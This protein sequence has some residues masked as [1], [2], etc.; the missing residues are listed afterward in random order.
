MISIKSS[1]ELELMRRSGKLTASCME[2]LISHVKPGVSTAQLDIIAEQ[3]IVSKGAWPSFKNYRGFPASVCTSVNEE[4]VHGIPSKDKILKDGDILSLD[5]GALLDGYHS[6]MARTVGVGDISGEAKRLISATRDCFYAGMNEAKEGRRLN[7]ISKAVE[8]CAS[9]NGYSV[10]R[11]LVGHGIGRKLHEAPDVPNY[12]F[13]GA[14]PRLRRGMVLCIE[15][16]VNMGGEDVYW[17]ADGWLVI[18][19]DNSL[20]AHYENTVAV[21]ENGPEILTVPG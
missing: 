16:M 4:V 10:V 11:A 12:A 13:K 7:D 5:F 9:K 17:A 6:D 2:E 18:T 19:K 15:P 8:N 1:S 20:S 14:N 21:T 3:F